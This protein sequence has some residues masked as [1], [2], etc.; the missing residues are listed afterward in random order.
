MMAVL[1]T[2]LVSFCTVSVFVLS[3]M[4]IW[5]IYRT[6]GFDA[7]HYLDFIDYVQSVPTLSGTVAG[8]LAFP[9]GLC[10]LSI[11][12]VLGIFA[13]VKPKGAIQFARENKWASL[14]DSRRLYA[15]CI[16]QYMANRKYTERD[17]P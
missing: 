17:Y 6:L 3:C 13:L 12:V 1:F 9:V 14:C 7:T 4:N 2:V 10:I 15:G 16:L 8:L 11:L 5:S